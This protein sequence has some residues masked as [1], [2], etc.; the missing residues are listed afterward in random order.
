[1]KTRYFILILIFTLLFASCKSAPLTPASVSRNT[2]DDVYPQKNTLTEEEQAFADRAYALLKEQYP[3]F[4]RIPRA[5]LNESVYIGDFQR[6]Q[7]SFCLGGYRTD[8]SCLYSVD[9]QNPDGQWEQYGE[10]LAPFSDLVMKKEDLASLKAML[11]ASVSAWIEEN[12]LT[13]APTD[14]TLNLYWTLDEGKLYAE[15]EVIAAVT[16]E[17]TKEFGCG[18]HAHVFGSVLVEFTDGGVRLTDLGANG[19]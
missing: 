10:E 3:E 4:Y 5:L 6:V 9:S 19:S 14:E 2:D 16:E 7:F 17:T 12:R 18:D 1:M 8:Y 15:T 13:G 11:I